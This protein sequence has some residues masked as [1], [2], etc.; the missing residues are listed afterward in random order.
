MTLLRI[1]KLVLPT[2]LLFS[3][4]CACFTYGVAVGRYKVFPYRVLRD[5][6]TAALAL[7]G[8][9]QSPEISGLTSYR[10]QVLVPTVRKHA[11]VEVEELLLV[12]GGAGYHRDLNPAG[13]QAWLMNRD[14]EIKHFWK[15]DPALW[16]EL[17]VVTRIPGVSGEISAAGMHL[18]TNG[19]LLLTY[20]GLNTFP[21]AIGMARRAISMAASKPPFLRASS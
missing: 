4:G 21:F 5:A 7:A 14:G 19:D 20:H 11:P 16:N 18:F 15:H 2:L 3:M 8:A 6:R 9:S 17:D 1:Q 13:C 10:D 12:S